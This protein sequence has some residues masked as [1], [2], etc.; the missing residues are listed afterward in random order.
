MY[1]DDNVKARLQ[2]LREDAKKGGYLLNSD[3]E[4]VEALVEGLVANQERYGIESCPCRLYKGTVEDNQDIV[5]PCIYRDDDL[6]EFGAC[7][8]SLYIASEA[9]GQAQKQVPERRPKLAD[10]KRKNQ[11]GGETL[12]KLEYPVYRCT[13][14]GYLCANNNPPRVCPICKATAER[15]SQFI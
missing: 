2:K 8:C 10:R 9:D 3:D 13:V 5:C 6:A 1:N 15:F 11:I 14:C 7:Y 12:G 4:V